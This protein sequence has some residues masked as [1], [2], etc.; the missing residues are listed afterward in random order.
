MYTEATVQHLNESISA[1]EK[2]AEPRVMSVRSSQQPLKGMNVTSLSHYDG[3]TAYSPS[4]SLSSGPRNHQESGEL[5]ETAEDDDENDGA[6]AE[7]LVQ[8]YMERVSMRTSGLTKNEAWEI[9]S[10]Y[11]IGHT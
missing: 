10:K 4:L 7:E 2:G 11:H 5:E 8:K 1:G 9:D 6:S 3:S